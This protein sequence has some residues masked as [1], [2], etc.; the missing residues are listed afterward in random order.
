LPG[1]N[2]QMDKVLCAADPSVLFFLFDTFYR[3]P[4][5]SV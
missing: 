1:R 5:T 4:G 3:H 2:I